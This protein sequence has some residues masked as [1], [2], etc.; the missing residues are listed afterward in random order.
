MSFMPK[1]QLPL[2]LRKLNVTPEGPLEIVVCHAAGYVSPASPI[3]RDAWDV[4]SQPREIEPSALFSITFESYIAYSSGFE[5]VVT[6]DPEAV[7]EG[8]HFLRFRKSRYLRY[9]ESIYANDVYPGTRFHYGIYCHNQLIDIVSN[10][11]P[12]ITQFGIQ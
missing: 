11:A 7:C 8:V 3:G 1:L 9:I 2:M 4:L 5:G 6:K 12:T 10:E